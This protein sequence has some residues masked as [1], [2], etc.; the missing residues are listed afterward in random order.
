MSGYHLAYYNGNPLYLR[1]HVMRFH[2]ECSG[3]GYQAEFLTRLISE[4]ATFKE[5]PLI[6]YDRE[7]SAALSVKNLL[8]VTTRSS[9]SRF[10]VCGLSSSNEHCRATWLSSPAISDTPGLR[11]A[12]DV[13]A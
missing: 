1:S 3:F 7:R 12:G 11:T 5:I 2:V 9:P 6:A 8:S 4:G 10:A 13:G